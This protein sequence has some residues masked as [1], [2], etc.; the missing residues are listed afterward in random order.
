M[1]KIK[2]YELRPAGSELLQDS[3]SFLNELSDHDLE[4]VVGGDSIGFATQQ[5]VSAA[6]E[7]RGGLQIY[8]NPSV[9]YRFI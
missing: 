9:V 8:I 5:T 3:E 6:S 1:A 4:N 2:I 7:V